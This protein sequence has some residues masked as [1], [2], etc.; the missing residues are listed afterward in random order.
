MKIIIYGASEFG[1]LIA[2]EF[3]QQHDVVVIDNEENKSDEFD[4]LDISFV[5]GSASDIDILSI[6]VLCSLRMARPI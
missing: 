4:K 5:N 2:N 3:Y 6:S 1:Y